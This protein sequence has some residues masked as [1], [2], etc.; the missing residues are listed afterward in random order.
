MTM[1]L[2]EI[3]KEKHRKLRIEQWRLEVPFGNS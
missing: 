1:S 2:L 3:E